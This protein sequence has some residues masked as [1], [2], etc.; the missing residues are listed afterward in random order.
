MSSTGS[1]RRRVSPAVLAGGV[2]LAATVVTVAVITLPFL[3]FA[4][5]APALHV[6]LETANALIALLL[7][8]LVYGRFRQERR[9]QDLL[10]VLALATAAIANLAFTAVPSAVTISSGEEFS[11]WTAVAVRFLGTVLLA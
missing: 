3:G 6:V 11:R 4:Y 8:Y 5:R 1:D 2:A 9:L 7:A 10:L